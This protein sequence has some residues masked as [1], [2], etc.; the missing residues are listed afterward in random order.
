MTIR[1]VGAQQVGDAAV[2]GRMLG[3]GELG[4]V[5]RPHLHCDSIALFY[6]T[7]GE[8][9]S[10]RGHSH[11]ESIATAIAAGVQV[12]DWLSGGS[13]VRASP[14]SSRIEADPDHASDQKPTAK[15][16]TDE[17]E[18]VTRTFG[19]A[20]PHAGKQVEPFGGVGKD[21]NC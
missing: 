12:L 3:S 4:A 1:T 15:Y 21:H 7:A 17:I 19:Q 16:S 6:G 14:R 2:T 9:L 18:V 10:L 20:P 8:I 11:A 5:H 13:G